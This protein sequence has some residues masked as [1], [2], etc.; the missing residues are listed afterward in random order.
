MRTTAA[1]TQTWKGILHCSGSRVSFAVVS[2]IQCSSV[3][4]FGKRFGCDLPDV[5]A[6]PNRWPQ[7]L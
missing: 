6:A 3:L 2:A 5:C 7:Q 1:E 4:A